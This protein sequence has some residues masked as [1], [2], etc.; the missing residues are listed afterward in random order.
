MV[1]QGKPYYCF[2][3][4]ETEPQRGKWLPQVFC[5]SKDEAKEKAPCLDPQAALVCYT[6]TVLTVALTVVVMRR[7][8]CADWLTRPVH[9]PSRRP[10]PWSLP[11]LAPLLPMASAVWFPWALVCIPIT[12]AHHL[13]IIQPPQQAPWGQLSCLMLLIYPPQGPRQCWA[14]RWGGMA[15]LSTLSLS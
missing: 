14:Q 1:L 3:F 2:M 10:F 15:S 9:P 6:A 4:K 7:Q 11:P 5:S 8:A 13:C 12:L